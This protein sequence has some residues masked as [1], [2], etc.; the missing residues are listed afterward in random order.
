MKVVLDINFVTNSPISLTYIAKKSSFGPCK[1]AFPTFN[2]NEINYKYLVVGPHQ[3]VMKE[4]LD[5]NF[6]TNS[7]IL[8]MYLAK[9][10]SFGPCKTAFPTFN[11]NEINYN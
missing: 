8:L 5:I 3:L 1:T 10:S 11:L 7:P 6:V 9:K 4:L 2:L